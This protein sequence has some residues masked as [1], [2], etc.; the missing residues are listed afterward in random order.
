MCLFPL[1][2]VYDPQKRAVENWSR[3]EQIASFVVGKSL[4]KVK[5]RLIAESWDLADVWYDLIFNQSW[6]REFKH[7]HL[8]SNRNDPSVMQSV[9]P[10]SGCLAIK[11]FLLYFILFGPSSISPNSL[12]C[13]WSKPTAWWDRVV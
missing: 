6:N 9:F 5:R 3:R 4:K 8:T 2:I 1:S 13:F 12:S 7:L 11:D 10:S